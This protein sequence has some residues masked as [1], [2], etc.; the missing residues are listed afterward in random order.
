MNLFDNSY[1]FLPQY[2]SDVD[3]DALKDELKKFPLDGTKGNIYSYEFIDSQYLLQGDGIADV[4]YLSFP[5]TRIK[6]LAV[7]ILSNTCDIS[8][9]NQERRFNDC[10]ILYAPLIRFDKYEELLRRN[11]PEG[12]DLSRIESHLQD[13]KSQFVTQALYLP[14]DYNALDYDSIVFFDRAISIPLNK[15]I[16]NKMCSNRK[17][18]LSNFGFYLF[19]LKLSIHFTRIKEK[20]NRNSGEDLGIKKE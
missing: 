1:L 2:L 13:I 14:K 18:S 5:D 12:K 9:E 20:I 10:R 19:L 15:H 3:K 16:A 7:I 17:F 6:N 8:I 4:E 11:Y